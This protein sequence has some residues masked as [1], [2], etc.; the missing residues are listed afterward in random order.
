MGVM[1][2]RRGFGSRSRVPRAVRIYRVNIE[3]NPGRSKTAPSLYDAIFV[4]LSK[5][6]RHCSNVGHAKRLARRSVDSRLTAISGVLDVALVSLTPRTDASGSRVAGIGS[7]RWSH[8]LA[9]ESRSVVRRVFEMCLPD[10]CRWRDTDSRW[11]DT[12]V[13]PLGSPSGDPV[14][15]YL[16]SDAREPGRGHTYTRL[17]VP[18]QRH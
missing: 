17:D 9:V 11:R 18:C 5:I 12:A 14:A 16:D 10:T 2:Y 1:Q 3:L 8:F 7:A 13:E 6:G 4:S 15:I